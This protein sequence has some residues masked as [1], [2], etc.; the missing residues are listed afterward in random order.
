MILVYLLQ[1]SSIQ[2]ERKTLLK[3]GWWSQ[4]NPSNTTSDH[5]R[6]AGVTCNTAV[7]IT[8]IIL[9]N[10]QLK[11][12]FGRLKFSYMP[13]MEILSLEINSL[14]WKHSITNLYPFQAQMS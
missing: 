11:G 13:N 10:K 1:L 8:K 3:T 4:R 5:C 7:R 9:R 12:K 14:K 6:W 2:L